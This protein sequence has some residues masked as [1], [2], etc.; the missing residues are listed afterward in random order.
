MLKHGTLLNGTVLK[1]SLLTL[2]MLGAAATGE[3][4]R[5]QALDTDTAPAIALDELVPT[6]IAGWR[7]DERFALVQPDPDT[8]RKLDQLYSATLARAYVDASGYHIMLS[9][10]YGRRQT[11]TL[12][13][14]LPELCYTA[15]G[16]T[17]E[18]QQLDHL[19]LGAGYNALPVTRLLTRNALR[20]E[21]VTYWLNISGSV[22]NTQL[23]R[24]LTSLAFGLRGAIPDGMLVRVS[25]VDADS[26]RAFA[27]QDHFLRALGAQLSV[28]QRTQLFG[29]AIP[30]GVAAR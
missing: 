18:Q 29:I 9:I 30:T 28:A 25:S 12:R 4:L 16:F 13:A 27:Q 26:T 10:A 24:K 21:P 19:D 11:D 5:P 22:V 17:V 20:T 23:Q 14:H 6:Q 8:L 3:W 7:V 15:Q 2:A 1:A